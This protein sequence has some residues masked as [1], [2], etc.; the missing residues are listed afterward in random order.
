[1]IVQDLIITPDN[2]EFEKEIYYSSSLKKTYTGNVPNGYEGE[3]G[4]GIK[5]YILNSYHNSKMSH[6]A[7]VE[8]LQTYG[9]F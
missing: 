6:S 4:P 8:A 9:A 2:I 7:I 1:M 5:A 3:F